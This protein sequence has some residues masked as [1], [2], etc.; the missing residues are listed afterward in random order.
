[1][2]GHGVQGDWGSRANRE[3]VRGYRGVTPGGPGRG[4]RSPERPLLHSGAV[5]M[6]T[7]AAWRAQAQSQAGPLKPRFGPRATRGWC[8][9]G[10]LRNGCLS[11]KNYLVKNL[12]RFWKQLEREAGK[13]E[14]TKCAFISKTF[15]MLS[16]Y[17]LFV[18]EFH[19]NPGIA[20]IVKRVSR[21]Q[22]EGIWKLKDIIVK[23]GNGFVDGCFS[24]MS[25][26]QNCQ[27]LPKLLLYFLSWFLEVNTSPSL[28][29]RSQ[30]DCELGCHLPKDT[31]HAVDR[32][33]RSVY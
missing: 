21:S 12:K 4:F 16:E 14:A 17:H 26:W 23:K 8:T 18:E 20:W 10:G 25:H 9:A 3:M 22:G 11:Q 6:V 5:A 19:K 30:E 7:G 27:F 31:L 13:F 29:A 28:T 24:W 2:G 32:E 1:M 33:G 15:K